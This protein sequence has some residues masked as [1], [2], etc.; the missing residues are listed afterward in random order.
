MG[1]YRIILP[2]QTQGGFSSDPTQAQGNAGSPALD[3]SIT[4]R[5]AV[6]LALAYTQG[7]KVA[8]TLYNAT[9]DQIGDSR[10]EVAAI[11]GQKVGT[12]V[13]IGVATGGIGVAIMAGAEILT[14]GIGNLVESHKIGMD[15]D[16]KI[17]ERGVRRSFGVNY[18]D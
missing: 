5:N 18:Y 11:I 3:K 9:I 10:L 12:Y 16:I 2:K 14:M 17:M 4:A 13:A 8:S 7:K 15:N 6:V 1:E